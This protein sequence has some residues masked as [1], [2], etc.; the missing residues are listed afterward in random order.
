MPR[1]FFHVSDGSTVFIDD[2][3]VELESVAAARDYAVRDARDL[4]CRD[5]E[6]DGNWSGWRILV[7]DED[8]NDL[9]AV[10]FL[11]AVRGAAGKE[12]GGG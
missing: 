1:F 6:G 9:L 3:A 2:E 7:R 11:D 5:E 8:G 4:M 10:S 12:P